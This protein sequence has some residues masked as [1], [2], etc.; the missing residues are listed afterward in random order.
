MRQSHT[1]WP[2]RIQSGNSI[3]EVLHSGTQHPSKQRIADLLDR[4]KQLDRA[5]KLLWEDLSSRMQTEGW[6]QATHQFQELWKSPT[7]R[8]Y[9]ALLNR[10]NC[11][12]QRYRSVPVLQPPFFDIDEFTGLRLNWE[13]DRGGK[14]KTWENQAVQLISDV[15]ARKEFHRIRKCRNCSN[16]FYGQTDHQVHCGDKCRKEFATRNP[17]FKEKR[18]LYMRKHR[19][20]GKA[21]QEWA[22]AAARKLLLDKNRRTK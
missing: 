3:L 6:H 19:Q 16:W 1:I 10:T 14:W 2:T 11:L 7:E 21:R 9:D 17:A 22:K 8:R 5:E 15:I 12:L 13:L 20:E 4:L 18:R